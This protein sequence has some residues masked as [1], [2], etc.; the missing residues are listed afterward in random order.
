VSYSSDSECVIQRRTVYTV[1]LNSLTCLVRLPLLLYDRGLYHYPF[2]HARLLLLGL[3]ELRLLLLHIIKHCRS[4][5]LPS[6]YALRRIL[7]SCWPF[8]AE[9]LVLL[10]ENSL[11]RFTAASA[12]R[13]VGS[14][15]HTLSLSPP[16]LNMQLQ[17]HGVE[18]LSSPIRGIPHGDDRSHAT[19]NERVICSW[20]QMTELMAVVAVRKVCMPALK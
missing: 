19:G 8:V 15:T 3:G 4:R 18:F 12:F 5:R 1:N 20:F 14:H 10:P 13:Y 16:P 2:H 7:R 17:H 6:E 11:L 9:S